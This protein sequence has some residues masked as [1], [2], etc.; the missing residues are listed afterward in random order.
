VKLARNGWF[1]VWDR[2]TGQILNNPWMAV[3]TDHMQGVDLTTGRPLYAADTLMFT[4]LSARTDFFS[5]NF[6]ASPPDPLPLTLAPGDP[7][8]ASYT[9]TEVHWCPGLAARNWQ[10]DAY[11]PQTGL[12]Y[13]LT[14]TDCGRGRMIEETQTIGDFWLA[15]EA[16]GTPSPF[17]FTPT[18]GQPRNQLQANDPRAYSATPYVWPAPPSPSARVWMNSYEHGTGAPVLATAGNLLFTGDTSKGTVQA[19]SAST[20]EELW[21]FRIGQ[22]V[23][24]SP[25]TYRL[26]GRQ[27]IAVIGSA[28][29]SGH[30]APSAAGDDPERYSR[31]GAN[32][33]IFALP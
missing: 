23:S 2:Q 15:F 19:L 8:P 20:G 16:W 7:V 6:G 33:Y 12:V 1:Y 31:A 3:P 32:L 14:D 26:N 17:G 28:A 25:V 9:G 4:D 30:V 5:I 22:A 29:T 11:S 10:N 24:A 21:S 27:Y 18:P 13:T